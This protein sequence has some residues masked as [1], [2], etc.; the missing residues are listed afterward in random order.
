MQ[1]LGAGNTS[2][3]FGQLS[4]YVI[5]RAGPIRIQR[6]TEKYAEYGQIAFIA[7]VRRDGNLLD[8]GSH[9]VKTLVNHP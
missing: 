7:F 1:T 8:A 9:P 2:I 6:L 3:V 4:K 5:R